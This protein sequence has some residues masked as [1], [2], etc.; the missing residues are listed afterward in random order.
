MLTKAPLDHLF[1]YRLSHL[2]AHVLNAVVLA[3]VFEGRTGQHQFDKQ[4]RVANGEVKL[5]KSGI[6]LAAHSDVTWH[7]IKGLCWL[8]HNAVT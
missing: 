2:R 1:I 7:L 8:T 3:E 4:I 5:D 6:R